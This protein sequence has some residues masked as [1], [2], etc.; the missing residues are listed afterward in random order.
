M[1]GDSLAFTQAKVGGTYIPAFCDVVFMVEGD[2]SMYL[3]SPRM[4]EMVIDEKITLD[5]MGGARMHCEVAG[6]ADLL[7]KDE[8]SCL[9]AARDYF[10]FMPQHADARVPDIASQDPASRQ[11][12]DDIIPDNQNQSF[13]M[14]ALITNPSGRA[15][16]CSWIRPTRPRASCS[17]ATPSTF[18]CCF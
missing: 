8:V 6:C 15:A 12:I 10:A 18:P 17:C 11:R 2:A 4:A 3:G 1:T 16:C 7:A 13:D 9:Q 5:E 14:L